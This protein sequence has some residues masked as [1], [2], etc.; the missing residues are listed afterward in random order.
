MVLTIFLELI[1]SHFFQCLIPF[2]LIVDTLLFFQNL[3][4]HIAKIVYILLYLLL[5][6]HF[7]KQSLVLLLILAYMF[8]HNLSPIVDFFQP[9]FL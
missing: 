4:H 7:Y 5:L 9:F 2:Q 6:Q 8:F 1:Q 3:S